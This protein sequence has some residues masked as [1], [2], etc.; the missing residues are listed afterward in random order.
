MPMTRDEIAA[1]PQHPQLMDPADPE[2]LIVAS[3]WWYPSLFA[4]RTA[5]LQ[6]LLLHAG[7]GYE[8]T[9]GGQVRSVFAHLKPD[10]ATLAERHDRLGPGGE[11]PGLA[12][13]RR[14]A[15]SAAARVRA[16][17][18]DRA[19]AHGPVT[20]S[21]GGPVTGDAWCLM[22]ARPAQVHPR[23]RALLGEAGAVFARA[24]AVQEAAEARLRMQWDRGPA[25]RAARLLARQLGRAWAGGCVTDAEFAACEHVLSAWCP[26]LR[27]DHGRLRRERAGRERALRLLADLA[28]GLPDRAPAAGHRQPHE[29]LQA[30]AADR[31]DIVGRLAGAVPFT[32]W[33]EW[34]WTLALVRQ[35]SPVARPQPPHPQGEQDR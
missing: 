8:W 24:Q 12:A 26:A 21:R 6:H 32:A 3:I 11:S 18:R 30:M 10:Y 19:R 35:Q 23:W 20:V 28:G 1:A 2:E 16:S 31:L 7:N 14:E 13:W 22:A 25:T 34:D 27:I 29:I 17:A 15:V 4:H 33:H 5:V 9:S